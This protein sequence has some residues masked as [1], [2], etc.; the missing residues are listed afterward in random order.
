MIDCVK[1]AISIIQKTQISFVLAAR[2]GPSGV[3][4]TRVALRRNK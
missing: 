1:N 2:V 3:P 4:C